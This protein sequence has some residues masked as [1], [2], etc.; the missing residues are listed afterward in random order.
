[1]S[2]AR[3]NRVLYSTVVALVIAA[4]TLVGSFFVPEVRR[5]IGLEKPTRVSANQNPTA[6]PAQNSPGPTSVA[7]N[8]ISHRKNRIKVT[9]HKNVVGN[10]VTGKE[11]VVGNNNKTDSTSVSAPV[12]VQQ[13]GKNNISQIGNDNHAEI[14]EFD[15][16]K[17]QVRYEVNG[18]RH[19]AMPGKN[20]A[21]DAE[22]GSYNQLMTYVNSHDWKDAHDLAAAEIKRAPEWPTPYFVLGQAAANLCNEQE[23]SENLKIFLSIARSRQDYV[24]TVKVAETFLGLMDRGEP[25]PQC[26]QH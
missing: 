15:P 19:T 13:T 17:P 1:M 18:I 20:T 24:T 4:L 25:P 14:T 5:F 23:A 7:P 12:T 26:T 6:K 8:K 3:K 10:I 11:N 21:D 2:R 9:G 16:T 22:V